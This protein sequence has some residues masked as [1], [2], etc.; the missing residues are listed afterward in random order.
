MPFFALVSLSAGT[1][2]DLFIVTTCMARWFAFGSGL[3]SLDSILLAASRV[4]LCRCQPPLLCLAV[5]TFLSAGGRDDCERDFST[6]TAHC[7][8]VPLFEALRITS[9]CMAWA[10]GLSLRLEDAI[11]SAPAESGP[12]ALPRASDRHTSDCHAVL[13]SPCAPMHQEPAPSLC[14]RNGFD[15]AADLSPLAWRASTAF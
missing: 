10:I 15:C 1:G 7:L 14:R 2:L 13:I 9:D 11:W 5:E 6:P 8:T 12:R 3:L 4:R